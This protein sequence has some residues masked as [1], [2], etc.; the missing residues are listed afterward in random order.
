MKKGGIF[1]NSFDAKLTTAQGE[2]R[3]NKFRVNFTAKEAIN[4]L[5]GR[6]VKTEFTNA[7]T[8][9][10]FVRLKFNEPKNEYDNY[11]ME[12]QQSQ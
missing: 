7:K 3:S 10:P 9:E 2:E 5:E 1:L 11:K 12:F 6:A 8:N 4:L